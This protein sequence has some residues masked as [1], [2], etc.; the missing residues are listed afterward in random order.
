MVIIPDHRCTDQKKGTGVAHPS[1]GMTPTFQ[2]LTLLTSWIIFSKVGVMP[3]EGWVQPARPSF[4]WYDDKDLKV[5]FLV[6]RITYA[7]ACSLCSRQWTL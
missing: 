7:S 2:N 4:F 1:F 6:T 3:K 5:C